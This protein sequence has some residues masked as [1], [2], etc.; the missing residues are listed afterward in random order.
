MMKDPAFQRQM[1]SFLSDKDLEAI[2]AQAMEAME[3]VRNDPEQMAKMAQFMQ[4]AKAPR[5]RDED[6]DKKMRASARAQAGVDMGV[7]GSGAGEKR[8]VGTRC[9]PHI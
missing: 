7:P 4:S 3:V 8:G 6:L 5:Q 2:A 9:F 1:Q